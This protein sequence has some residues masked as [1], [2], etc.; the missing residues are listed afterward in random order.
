MIKSSNKIYFILY[1][2][3]LYSLK[4]KYKQIIQRQKETKPLATENPYKREL[5][6]ISPKDTIL[7]QIIKDINPKLPN[8]LINSEKNI[9]FFILIPLKS[10]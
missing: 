1:F 6:F 8:R 7:Y 2:N 10:F 3:F 5:K 4:L 9:I